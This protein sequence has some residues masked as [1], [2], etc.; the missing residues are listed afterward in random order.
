MRFSIL[1]I[2]LIHLIIANALDL[3]IKLEN[4]P[5]EVENDISQLH[6]SKIPNLDN[7]NRINAQLYLLPTSNQKFKNI[8]FKPI[9]QSIAD[10]NYNIKFKNLQN[11]N[12]YELIINPY[13]FE[14]VQN[15]F[16]INVTND[17]FIILEDKLGSPSLN[18]TTIKLSSNEPLKISFRNYIQFY[19]RSN[20][21]LMQMLLNSP[22]GFIFKN[23]VYTMLFFV[24]IG[25]MIAPY[26]AEWVNPEFAAQFKDVPIQDAFKTLEQRQEGKANAK[27]QIDRSDDIDKFLSSSLDSSNSGTPNPGQ[28]HATGRKNN[29]KSTLRKR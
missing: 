5:L 28:S 27:A 11:D 21:T 20:G 8:N 19:E 4:I 16:K 14:L 6:K 10:K 26:V 9:Q 2:S 7:T 17:E 12:N 25:L 1:I 18:E 3:N 29:N 23:K 22:L 15:R 13:D 24:C